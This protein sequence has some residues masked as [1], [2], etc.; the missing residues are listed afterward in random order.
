MLQYDRND[1]SEGIDIDKTNKS[2]KCMFAI[3][4]I[5]KMLVI[6]FNHIFVMVVML[7]Q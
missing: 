6:D 1:V 2:K 3:I 5:L 4:G 7:C